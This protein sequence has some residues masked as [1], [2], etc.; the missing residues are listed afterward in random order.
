MNLKEERGVFKNKPGA[1]LQYISVIR[2]HSSS[3]ASRAQMSDFYA[4]VFIAFFLTLSNSYHPILVIFHSLSYSLSIICNSAYSCC[5]RAGVVSF[6]G[7]AQRICSQHQSVFIIHWNSE[8]HAFVFEAFFMNGC[9]V[10]A[11]PVCLQKSLLCN[12]NSLNRTSIFGGAHLT[13]F[14]KSFTIISFSDRATF[15]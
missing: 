9:S 11:L 15:I 13:H 3:R 1:S 4:L 10:I 12:R 7:V 6:D 5:S 2:R 14:S 8:K